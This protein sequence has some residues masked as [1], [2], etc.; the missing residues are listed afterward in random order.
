VSNHLPFTSLPKISFSGSTCLSA[1]KVTL[2]FSVIVAFYGAKSVAAQIPEDHHEY[3][4]SA[5]ISEVIEGN[6]NDCGL[7]YVSDPAHLP[8]NNECVDTEDVDVK[9]TETLDTKFSK[10]HDMDKASVEPCQQNSILNAASNLKHLHVANPIEHNTKY[11]MPIT[12]DYVC[13]QYLHCYFF[14]CLFRSLVR[15]TTCK[16]NSKTLLESWFHHC[17]ELIKFQLPIANGRHLSEISWIG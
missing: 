10:L 2:C 17:M 8:E 9:G 5:H 15:L 16:L 3:P 4:S 7:P 14:Q 1:T 13:A 11:A 12:A 6:N